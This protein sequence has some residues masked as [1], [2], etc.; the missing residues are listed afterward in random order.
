M[1]SASIALLKLADLINRASKNLPLGHLINRHKSGVFDAL[2]SALECH[3]QLISLGHD[4][5]IAIKQR[6]GQNLAGDL[7]L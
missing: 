6:I 4:G 7:A 5:V 3:W 1:A 2:P